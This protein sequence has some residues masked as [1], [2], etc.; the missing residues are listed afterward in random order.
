M[1]SNARMFDIAE[2][3]GKIIVLE[4]TN[5]L[6][7]FVKKH[8]ETGNMQALQSKYTDKDVIWVSIVS[9]ANDKQGHI[10]TNEEANIVFSDRGSNP[11]HIILDE[12]GEIGKLYQAATTPHMFVIDREGKLAYQGAIDSISSASKGDVE[13][14]DNYVSLALDEILEGKEVSKKISSPYGCSVK[15]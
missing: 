8:Y 6:C 15:Y 14:A 11:S 9:S 12:S 1:D 4:W 10:D 13:K 2:N 3:N 7:P 5:H